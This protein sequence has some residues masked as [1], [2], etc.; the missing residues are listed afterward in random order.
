M[1][2]IFTFLLAMLATQCSFAQT[3]QLEVLILNSGEFSDPS[4]S[5]V[6]QSYN[7]TTSAYNAADTIHTPSAQ[8]VLVDGDVAF[9]AA[10]DSIVKI[11][12]TNMERLATVEFP[13]VST[14]N[15]EVHDSLLIAGNFYGQTDSNLYVFNKNTLQLVAAVQGI[16]TGVKGVA[17]LNDSLY[18]SQ[19][20]TSSTYSDSAGYLAVVDMNT[21]SHVRDI[22]PASEADLGRLF[23]YN[24]EVL[25]ISSVTDSLFYI[26]PATNS[27]TGYAIGADIKGN[28]GSAYQLVDDTLLAV[29]GSSIGAYDVNA[30]YLMTSSITDSLVSSFVYDTEAGNFYVTYTDFFATHRAYVLNHDGEFVEELTAGYAP[31]NVALWRRT[32]TGIASLSKDISLNVYPNPANGRLFVQTDIELSAL[33]IT[34]LTG[35]VVA[36]SEVFATG[37]QVLHV[38]HLPQ[39]AYIVV[40][41]SK[42]GI[43]TARFVKQ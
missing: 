39:G 28:Y 1:G 43:Q 22:N 32:V 7:T 4:N 12:L 30:N 29:F 19:N 18:V 34:S 36:Q 9:I 17:I 35:Q 24:G 31:E 23:V 40:A 38:A 16:T 20:L 2:R 5:V 21:W 3:T 8:Q 6:L 42:Q 13:G 27:I 41:Q 11:D 14:Y 26:D 10:Q 33:Y 25:A 37:T 15:I